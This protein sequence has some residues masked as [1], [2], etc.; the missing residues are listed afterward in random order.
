MCNSVLQKLIAENCPYKL[1]VMF[2]LW[3]PAL[4]QAYCDSQATSVH[5]ESYMKRKFEKF[6]IFCSD[7]M[8]CV[9]IYLVTSGD[10]H[11]VQQAA[12]FH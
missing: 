2:L 5:R 8:C 1:Q 9:G 3:Y 11:V 10:H 6:G 12:V 4:Q 7:M